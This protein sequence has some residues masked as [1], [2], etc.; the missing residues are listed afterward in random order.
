[1][2]EQIDAIILDSKDYKEKDAL[3]SV[4]SLKYGILHLVARGI[5]KINSKNASACLPFTY[6]K[7][8]VDLKEQRSLH[9]LQSAVILKSYRKIRE[10]L[11]KQSIASYF[12]EMIEKSNF[13]EDVFS[14]LLE[15]LSCL[16]DTKNPVSVLCLFQSIM[17]RMHGIEPFVDG[18]VRCGGLHNIYALSYRDGG[19]VCSSCYRQGIDSVQDKERLKKFRILC[20]AKWEHYEII[21]EIPF[22]YDDFL[23]V[24]TYF[25]EYA[26]I[27][28]KSIR[29]L[30]TICEMEVKAK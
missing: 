11:L 6:A 1:M 17:N 2:I 20:K 19:F 15:A 13:D 10:D 25:E 30:K 7:L 8:M 18:C 9:T 29:F 16:Q 24:Y 4:L 23:H 12:C 5:R 3:L 27:G 22:D 14:I 26:G 28:M 21:K